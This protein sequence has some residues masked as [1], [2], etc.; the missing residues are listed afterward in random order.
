M[1]QPHRLAEPFLTLGTVDANVTLDAETLLCEPTS[2]NL[3]DANVCAFHRYPTLISIPTHCP[4]FYWDELENSRGSFGM[5]DPPHGSC[6]FTW[7]GLLGLKSSYRSREG[8]GVGSRGESALSCL[9]A[10]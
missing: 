1:L 2:I 5:H 3:P 4:D 9:T 7:R 10:A 6:F 8:G